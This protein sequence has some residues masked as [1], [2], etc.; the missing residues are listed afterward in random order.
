MNHWPFII[1]AYA[2]TFVATAALVIGSW[3]AMRRVETEAA[4]LGRSREA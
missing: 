4:N 2:L 3:A 1:G